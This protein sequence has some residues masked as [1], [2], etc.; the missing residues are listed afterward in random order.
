M[1]IAS[2]SGL[3]SLYQSLAFKLLQKIQ[4]N[5]VK[6]YYVTS[7]SWNKAFSSQS[8]KS[9]LVNSTNLIQ[10]ILFN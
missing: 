3:V 6:K 8:F 5:F 2:I 4:K 7:F 10:I 9:F 1:P